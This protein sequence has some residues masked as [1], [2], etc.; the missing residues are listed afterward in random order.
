MLSPDELK[1]YQRQ[2]MIQGFGK[3]GQEK[4]K[5]AR[6]FLAGAG[7]LGSPAA[8]YLTAAGIGGI[9]VIDSDTVD[10]SNLNRQVL[11]WT[12][13]TGKLKVESAKR[14]LRALNPEVKIESINDRLT[15][16]NIDDV[17]KGCDAI[18]DAVDNLA[19]RYLLNRTALAKKIPLFHGAVAGFEGRAMTVLPGQSACLMCLYQG[20]DI[21]VKTPVIGTSPAIIAGI[22]VTEVIKYLTDIGQLLTNRFL[23]YDGLNMRFAEI[24]VSPDPN[25]K[26]CGC[27]KA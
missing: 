7:G 18:I 10:L 17:V 5:R 20:V 15:A 11:H 9:R 21:V 24:N 23:V 12:R 6:V 2:I 22:Q 16:E 14:K 26:H 8:I 25:C 19:T 4:L 13:D 1:R 27:S 3:E